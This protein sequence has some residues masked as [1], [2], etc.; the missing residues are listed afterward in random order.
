MINFFIT[1]CFEVLLFVMAVAPSII[2]FSIKGRISHWFNKNLKKYEQQLDLLKMQK[3]LQFSNVYTKRAEVIAD[4][5]KNI[6]ALNHILMSFPQYD[7]TSSDIEMEMN[8]K[9]KTDIA[10]VCLK[11]YKQIGLNIIYFPTETANKLE[12][13]QGNIFQY[14]DKDKNYDLWV[15]YHADE[16]CSGHPDFDDANFLFNHRDLLASDEMS[17]LQ[18]ELRTQFKELIGVDLEKNK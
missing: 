13:L 18:E 7:T 5:H 11:L 1:Y 16:Y 6:F 14:I 15:R 12:K 10:F 17:K 8:A 4:M 9:V 3:Q 2:I